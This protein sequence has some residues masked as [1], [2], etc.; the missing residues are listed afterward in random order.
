[1]FCGEAISIFAFLCQDSRRVFQHSY[2][3]SPLIYLV[4]A[5]FNVFGNTVVFFGLTMTSASSYVMLRFLQKSVRTNDFVSIFLGLVGLATVGLTDFYKFE[6]TKDVVEAG[7]RNFAIFGDAFVVAGMLLLELDSA[8]YTQFPAY[9]S[10]SSRTPSG[11]YL[12][13]FYIKML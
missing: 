6:A 7:S 9:V 12:K 10:V 3:S 13:N 11:N 8:I 4:S 2:L 5:T 1:M